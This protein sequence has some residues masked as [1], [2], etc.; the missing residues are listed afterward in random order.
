M[1]AI[2][3]NASFSTSCPREPNSVQSASVLTNFLNGVLNSQT[4]KLP[5]DLQN[6]QYLFV[7]VFK[8]REEFLLLQLKCNLLVDG[9]DRA[10]AFQTLKIAKM[11]QKFLDWEVSFEEIFYR[12]LPC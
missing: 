5:G 10:N 3:C 11:L 6:A 2:V 9:Q 1:L 7:A 12:R 8:F 4:E